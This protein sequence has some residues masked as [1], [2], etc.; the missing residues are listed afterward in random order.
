MMCGAH[1]VPGIR[2][3]FEAR[4]SWKQDSTLTSL[5]TAGEFHSAAGRNPIAASHQ[6]SAIS[7]WCSPLRVS[8]PEL[9]SRRG[10]SSSFF[11]VSS[12]ARRSRDNSLFNA[13]AQSDSSSQMFSWA[14][15][16]LG[17]VTLRLNGNV[18]KSSQELRK[19]SSWTRRPSRSPVFLPFLRSCSFFWTF[20]FNGV[21]PF[22]GVSSTVQ[23]SRNHNR[24]VKTRRRKK[25]RSNADPLRPSALVWGSTPRFQQEGRNGRKFIAAGRVSATKFLNSCCS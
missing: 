18:A 9:I 14:Q 23:R 3:F 22:D 16:P 15:R 11:G 10:H 21:A 13:K 7:S 12:T 20:P 5:P 25:G 6:L 24:N 8:V 2:V 1:N 4:A 19:R 17:P